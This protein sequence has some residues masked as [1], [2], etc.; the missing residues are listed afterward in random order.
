VLINNESGG[1]LLTRAYGIS[2]AY[3]GKRVDD[4]NW[5]HYAFVYDAAERHVYGYLDYVRYADIGLKEGQSLNTANDV[6]Y[7]GTTSAAYQPF[8]G[9]MDEI[10]ITRR[11]LRPVEFVSGHAVG[12]TLAE[13]TFDDP[14][15]PYALT[16]EPGLRPVLPSGVPGKLTDDGE[17]ASLSD[18]TPGALVWD[19]EGGSDIR[20]NSKSVYI[21]GGRVDWPSNDIIVQ[22]DDFTV[23]FFAKI[24]DYERYGNLLRVNRNWTDDRSVLWALF[25]SWDSAYPT[26]LLANTMLVT[27]S[28]AGQSYF[29][30]GDVPKDNRWHHYAF[31][32]LTG[33]TD[34]APTTTITMYRDYVQVARATKD[35]HFNKT[36][37]SAN[38]LSLA[39]TGQKAKMQGWFDAIRISSGILPT[40]KFIRRVRKGMVILFR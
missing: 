37:D 23:E 40:E 25:G 13:A 39:G 20:A 5:H 4:G 16:A 29:Y 7:I 19:G 17:T 36:K 33:G 35:G 14:D 9:W 1:T 27:N 38:R 24:Q 12:Q 6:L 31:T 10:R 3:N 18:V 11:A 8:D 21:N 28:V 2:D 22:P 30:L 34:A 32:F 15:A 26:Q